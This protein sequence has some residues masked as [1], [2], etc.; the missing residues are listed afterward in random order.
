MSGYVAGVNANEALLEGKLMRKYLLISTLIG[1][2]SDAIGITSPV[3]IKLFYF[4]AAFNLMIL[5]FY[6]NLKLP[7][8]YLLALTYLWTSGGLEV[9]LGPDHISLFLKEAIGITLM[10]LYFY[11]FVKLETHSTIELFDMYAIAAFWVSIFGIALSLAQ[12]LIHRQFVPVRSILSEPAAFATAIVPSFYYFAAREKRYRNRRLYMWT[13]LAAVILSASS[14][15]MLGLLLSVGLLLRRK[16]WGLMFAPIIVGVLFV[17]AYTSSEHFRVRFDDTVQSITALD[18][19]KANLSTYALVSNAYIA[20]RAFEDRP[21]FGY[22]IGGHAVAHERYI[23]DLPGAEAMGDLMNLNAPD[24][25]SLLLRTIS[26]LGLAGVGIIAFFI[27]KCWT[28]GDSI[29]STVS[30]AIFV[31]FCLVL[32]RAGQWFNSE[33]YFFVWSYVL[34]KEESRKSVILPKRSVSAILSQTAYGGLRETTRVET[35]GA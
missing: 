17:A 25:N 29:Y 3:N 7:K 15:G 31:Y 32:L 14:V 9:A 34:V 33:I 2:F 26:E 8:Y 20:V 13:I 30:V 6:W 22:G 21:F 27:I 11:L 28:P 4:V 35:Q 1:I 19:S 18:V 24:A 23:E 16:S 10:S 5:L 12:T